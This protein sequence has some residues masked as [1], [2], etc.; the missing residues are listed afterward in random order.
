L[1]KYRVHTGSNLSKKTTNFARVIYLSWSLH[2]FKVLGL[3][4]W[5]QLK[6]G[7]LV[8]ATTRKFDSYENIV[9]LTMAK[10]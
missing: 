3:G 5:A 6:M 4:K 9:K 8:A 10:M 7:S 2:G 1:N